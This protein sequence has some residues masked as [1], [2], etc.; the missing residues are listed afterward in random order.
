M[1]NGHYSHRHRREHL[2]MS[3]SLSLEGCETDSGG[4]SV[5]IQ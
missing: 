1:V 2:N 3:M 4:L 5:E